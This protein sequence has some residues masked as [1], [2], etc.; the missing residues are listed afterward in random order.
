MGLKWDAKAAVL[1]LASKGRYGISVI[2]SSS[3]FLH[4]AP[5]EKKKDKEIHEFVCL[6]VVEMWM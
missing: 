6:C 3:I 5:K 1:P 4:F 2:F